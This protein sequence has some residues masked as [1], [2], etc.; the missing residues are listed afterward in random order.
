MLNILEVKIN[1][2]FSDVKIKVI[3]ISKIE[4]DIKYIYLIK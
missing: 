4:N 1:E 2:Y 3:S